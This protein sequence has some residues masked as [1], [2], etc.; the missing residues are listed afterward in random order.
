M[1]FSTTTEIVDIYGA[2]INV[3][4]VSSSKGTLE[5][6][7]SSSKVGLERFK[8]QTQSRNTGFFALFS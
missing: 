3:N 1:F 5:C 8:L 4:F 7:L 6:T 2:N